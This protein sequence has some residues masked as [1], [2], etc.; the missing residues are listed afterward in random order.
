MK[1]GLALAGGGIR[2]IAHVG[3]LKAFEENNISIDMISG[4]SSGS[5]VATLY[6]MGYSADEI[7]KI[8][9]KYVG[10]IIK[11][12]SKP[13]LSE[14]NNVI[15]KKKISLSGLKT[16]NCIEQAYKEISKI[17]D[18]KVISDIKMPLYIT[19]VDA[20]E[21]KEY[22]FASKLPKEL[23][24]NKKYIQ[25]I[26]IATAV[27][28]SSS[29]TGVFTPCKYQDKLFFDGGV[30]DNVPSEILR[31]CGADRVISVNFFSDEI[32]EKSNILD[33][34]MK[35]LDI[36]GEKISE[37][38]IRE[39]DCLLTIKTEGTGLLDANK[40]EYCY[41]KGYEVAKKNM[42]KIIG[43]IEKLA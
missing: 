29:F 10:N 25:D 24:K 15:R 17:N 14:I 3:V 8:F 38:S 39:T 31:E 36:M 23:I 43:M 37:K 28:A 22:I 42:N 32:N 4:T 18:L 41:E 12:N 13:I 16:G 33:Y 34:V 6:A 30:L 20:K 7:Y 35:T 2:G 26:D 9:N 40:I 27:R 5:M 21:S 11:I 19:A 1:I